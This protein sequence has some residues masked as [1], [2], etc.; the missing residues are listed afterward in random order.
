MARPLFCLSLALLALMSACGNSKEEEPTKS[1]NITLAETE[2]RAYK[3]MTPEMAAEGI[4]PLMYVASMGDLGKVNNF[5]SRGADVKARDKDGW[6][7]L[8]HAT[9]GGIHDDVMRALIRAGADVNAKTSRNETALIL[10]AMKGKVEEVRVLVESG[11][12]VNVKTSSG[13]T[14]L[15]MAAEFGHS[16]EEAEAVAEILLKAGADPTI[17]DI[18]GKTALQYAKE[19]GRSHLARSLKR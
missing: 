19:N 13:E 5:I 2:G 7:A 16:D 1:T 11:T 10:S 17:K 6:T 4:T 3:P 12:D 18:L 8:H 9:L 15:I 14:A